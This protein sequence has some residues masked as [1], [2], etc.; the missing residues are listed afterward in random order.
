MGKIDIV[1]DVINQITK[2]AP[3]IVKKY[4]PHIA[5]GTVS[6]G[7][8]LAIG[9]ADKKKAVEESFKKGFAT[10]SEIYEKKFRLQTEAFLEKEKSYQNDKKEYDKL[11]KEYEKEITKLEKKVQKSEDEINEL[12]FLLDKKNE[13]LRLKIAV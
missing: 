9:K 4:A 12:R 6:A 1:K 3:R 13:L 10:A 2:N 5:T 11:I 7:I 8:G